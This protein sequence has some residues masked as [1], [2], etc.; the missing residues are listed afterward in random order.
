MSGSEISYEDKKKMTIKVLLD[1]KRVDILQILYRINLIIE[2]SL[3][4]LLEN[5]DLKE[6]KINEDEIDRLYHLCTKSIS[7]SLIDTGV[8]ES[9][10]IKN[11]SLIPGF[12]LISKR[13]E[14]IGDSIYFLSK[15]VKQLPKNKDFTKVIETLNMELNR[16]IKI[17][18]AKNPKH[19]EKMVTSDKA[20]IKDLISNFD[21][22]IVR[23]YLNDVLRYIIDIQEEIVN[24]CFYRVLINQD[25]L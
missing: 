25:I 9:S 16:S 5:T 12:F 11:I 10:S 4:S 8:L 17:I 3:K 19:F 1:I 21:N 2:L 6:M 14:N 23:R 13:L 15:E 20:K 18:I 22:R 24:T 7:L